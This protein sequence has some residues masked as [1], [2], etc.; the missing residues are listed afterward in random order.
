LVDIS[1]SY[2]ILR[3][4]L[5]EEEVEAMKGLSLTADGN[6]VV[7]YVPHIAFYLGHVFLCITFVLQVRKMKLM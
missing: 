1:F 5:P 4:F 7:F 2:G 3:R 6:G